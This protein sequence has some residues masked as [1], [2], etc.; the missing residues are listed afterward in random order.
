MPVPR[1]RRSTGARNVCTSDGKVGAAL[2][3][4]RMTQCAVEVIGQY[5]QSGDPPSLFHYPFR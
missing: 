2:Y 5:A 1:W 3:I 4:D